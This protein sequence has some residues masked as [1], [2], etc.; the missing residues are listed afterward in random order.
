MNERKEK[1]AADSKFMHDITSI[2]KQYMD[3]TYALVSTPK[4]SHLP[5]NSPSMAIQNGADAATRKKL[6]AMSTLVN[7]IIQLDKSSVT[8]ITN[9][10]ASGIRCGDCDILSDAFLVALR[11]SGFPFPAVDIA[12]NAESTEG[13]PADWYRHSFV[14]IALQ[15]FKSEQEQ[16][17][18]FSCPDLW[19]GR[20]IIVDP[21][22]HIMAITEKEM[23]KFGI[24]GQRSNGEFCSLSFGEYFV[25]NV[26]G[27][28]C[29]ESTL[30]S[31]S[32]HSGFTV[33]NM[34]VPKNSQQDYPPHIARVPE[35]LRILEQHK[36][37]ADSVVERSA[38]HLSAFDKNLGTALHALQLDKKEILHVFQNLKKQ[39]EVS[40]I[41]L[42]H[43]EG[44]ADYLEHEA[45][46]LVDIC[47]ILKAR[48]QTRIASPGY[49]QLLREF[50]GLSVRINNMKLFADFQYSVNIL[51]SWPTDYS[52]LEKEVKRLTPVY[53]HLLKFFGQ[54]IDGYS[55]HKEYLQKLN[56]KLHGLLKEE[57]QRH[58]LRAKL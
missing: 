22:N 6:D 14:V 34:Y 20:A 17:E 42:E 25:T 4:G 45:L 29:S 19:P 48:V 47:N 10:I 12:V 18:F 46:R 2:L 23:R 58:V 50:E 41:N 15:E 43:S 9:W 44:S 24:F 33:S 57:K 3:W 1:I 54:R 11:L 28:R 55:A 37:G 13:A 53:E 21:Y 35:R 27:R 36:K 39:L 26:E 40:V 16:I 38:I 32:E 49:S 8:H 51:A 30:K 56:D 5:I 31:M 7:R 52:H